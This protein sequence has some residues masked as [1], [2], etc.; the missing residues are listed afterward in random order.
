MKINITRSNDGRWYIANYG[1][2]W[3]KDLLQALKDLIP[4]DKETW[5]V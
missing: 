4:E 2:I 5:S 3:E 1:L